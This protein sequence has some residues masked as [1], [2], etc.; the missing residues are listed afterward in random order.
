M[1]GSFKHYLFHLFNGT[2]TYVGIC[3]SFTYKYVPSWYLTIVVH[4]LCR[5]RTF[6]LHLVL[7]LWLEM[8]KRQWSFMKTCQKVTLNFQKLWQAVSQALR[9]FFY[10]LSIISYPEQYS[11][12]W[13]FQ[14][15]WLF[16]VG[17]LLQKKLIAYKFA[18]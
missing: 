9:W 18:W 16:L 17:E 4:M 12:W 10:C 5:K 3:F 1:I 14:V 11:S 7:F 2:C 15:F 6:N 13:L 8:L